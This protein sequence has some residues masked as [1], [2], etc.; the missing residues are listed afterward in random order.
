MLG[1]YW[2]KMGREGIN[3]VSKQEIRIVSELITDY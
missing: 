3:S 2:G 1:L